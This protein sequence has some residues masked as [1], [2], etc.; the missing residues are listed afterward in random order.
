MAVVLCDLWRLWIREFLDE[1]GADARRLVERFTTV[2]TAVTGNLDFSIWVRSV[3][4]F[5]VVS[6][7]S[8]RRATVSTW[9]FVVLVPVG[10]GRLLLIRLVLAR[11]CMRPLVPPDLGSQALV[12]FT[13]LLILLLELF[14]LLLKF[15]NT[16]F[17]SSN[18]LN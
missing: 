16:I 18:S 4:P 5:R 15:I 6:G 2:W 12:L 10:R 9:L 3:A 14:F 1:S 17:E 13:E 7:L 11:W 8:A